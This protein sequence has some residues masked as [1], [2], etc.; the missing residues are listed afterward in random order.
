[1]TPPRSAE[2]TWRSAAVSSTS[3]SALV[4]SAS[5][6]A[7]SASVLSLAP[8]HVDKRPMPRMSKSGLVEKDMT[9]RSG[10]LVGVVVTLVVR[11]WCVARC[12]ADVAHSTRARILTRAPHGGHRQSKSLA[13]YSRIR[14]LASTRPSQCDSELQL[15]F[16]TSSKDDLSQVQYP[17]STYTLQAARLRTILDYLS[18]YPSM[19]GPIAFY[20]GARRILPST[21]AGCLQSS[22]T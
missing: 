14:I 22:T 15:Q 18:I 21:Q 5:S 4:S 20:A 16:I 1:M 11:V 7:R 19:G 13:H 10:E 17:R 6:C 3:A 8:A 2:A 9:L 12:C